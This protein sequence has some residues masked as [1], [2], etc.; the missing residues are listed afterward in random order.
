METKDDI[1]DFEGIYM[2]VV[3]DRLIEYVLKDGQTVSIN[4]GA[5]G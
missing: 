2:N 1:I 4:F 5:N 3:P